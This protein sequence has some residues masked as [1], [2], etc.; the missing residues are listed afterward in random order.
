MKAARAH[1]LEFDYRGFGRSEGEPE[2]AGVCADAQAALLALERETG[3]PLGRIVV[4]GHSLGGAVATDV[5]WRKPA[6]GGLIVM[7]SFTSLDDLVADLTLPLLG[8]LIAESWE[9]IEKVPDIKKPKLFIHGTA[10]GLIPVEHARELHAAAAEPKE[11]LVVEG[12]EHNS[13]LDSPGVLDA[14]GRFVDGV[15]P[16]TSTE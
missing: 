13:V 8:N 11:L 4:F 6:V 12:G 7:A 9:S 16:V 3:V 5:A 10:D 14:I 2:E 15:A 1:V